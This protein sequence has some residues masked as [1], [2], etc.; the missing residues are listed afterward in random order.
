[1][2]RERPDSEMRV[3]RLFDRESGRAFITAIDYG[4][5]TGVQPETERVVEAVGYLTSYDPEGI[6]L[7]PGTLRHTEHPFAFHGAPS[8]LLRT[9][10][11]LVG[12]RVKGLGEHHRVLLSPREAA[13]LGADAVTM[14]LAVGA[15]DGAMLADNAQA[16]SRATYEARQRSA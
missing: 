2:D 9:D 4:L 11:L 16:V 15:E 7:S 8:I 10:Y 13:S 12:E 6:L 3:G 1:M 5:V 14:F